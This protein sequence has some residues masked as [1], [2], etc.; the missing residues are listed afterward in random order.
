MTLATED[1]GLLVFRSFRRQEMRERIEKKVELLG[2]Y[3]G[4]EIY[5]ARIGFVLLVIEL[6]ILIGILK[7]QV[8]RRRIDF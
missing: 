1:G 8:G 5:Q 6:I 7:V 3:C 4:K 2:E